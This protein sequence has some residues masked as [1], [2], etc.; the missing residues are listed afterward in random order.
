VAI[1]LP[2]L[3]WLAG[4][5]IHAQVRDVLVSPWDNQG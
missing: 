2:L 5:A 3:L 4:G 1:G